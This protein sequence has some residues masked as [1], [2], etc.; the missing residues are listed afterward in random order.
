[1]LDKLRLKTR[2]EE[3]KNLAAKGGV[4][5]NIIIM[6]PSASQGG[7]S[8]KTIKVGFINISLTKYF[9]L[10]YEDL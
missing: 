4:D 6:P 9:T 10:I 8:E 3:A 5:E 7:V 1:M 2:K